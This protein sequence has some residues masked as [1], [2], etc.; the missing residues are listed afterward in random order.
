MQTAASPKQHAKISMD[1]EALLRWAY[2]DELSKRQSSSAEGIWDRILDYQNHGGIDSGKGAAQ[3]YSHFGLPD[4]DAE[5]IEKAVSALPETVIDWNTHLEEIAGDL[6]GLVSIN[7]LSP[8]RAG[9]PKRPKAGWGDAGIRALKGFFG[10]K[11]VEPL[12]DRPRDIL[13]VGGIKTNMLVTA[14]AIKGTRPDWRDDEPY[15]GMTRSS[16][17]TGA[18]IE[19]ECRGKNLYTTGSYCPLSWSPSPIDVVLGRADYFAWYQG[20]LTLSQ[21]MVLE[22]FEALPPKAPRLP[23]FGDDEVT[24]RVIPVMPTGHNDVGAWGTLALKPVR[25]RAGPPRRRGIARDEKRP[26]GL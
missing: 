12:H 20:L 9:M 18:M 24:S 26:A 2:V 11:G 16:R 8:W 14:H 17:G 6:A 23:W 3:R 25:P 22:R 19:G 7:D 4:P 5:L 21:T 1:V 10:N 13:I 15:P